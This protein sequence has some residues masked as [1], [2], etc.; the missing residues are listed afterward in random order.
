M[1]LESD[2]IQERY[3]VCIVGT[4]RV[5]LPLG[6]SLME[7]GLNVIGMDVDPNLRDAVNAGR[8]PFAEPGYDALVAQRRLQIVPEP[9]IVQ[10][11]D[12]IVITVGT[13]LHTH[14]ETD[15]DQIRRVLDGIGPYLR[16]GHLLCLR[17]TVGPGTT[18]YVRRWIERNTSLRIGEDLFLAFCPERIAEGKAYEELRTLPQIVGAED[19]TSELPCY[20]AAWHRRSW[21]RIT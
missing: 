16:A 15:L 13:P 1:M 4:G 12:A 10:K 7:S 8:M 20:L 2:H 3:D 19:A 17:S 6:L 18:N 5:G 11:C 14:I 9:G 21:Q